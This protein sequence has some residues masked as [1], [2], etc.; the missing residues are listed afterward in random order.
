MSSD[1]LQFIREHVSP[2]IAAMQPGEVTDCEG[3]FDPELWDA[4]PPSD[5]RHVFGRP[6]SRLIAQGKVKL[7]FIGFDGK[8]HNL[9]RK[10]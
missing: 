4:V 9:Y 7:E 10:K 8:R 2:R 6:I 1:H 5:H 3:L